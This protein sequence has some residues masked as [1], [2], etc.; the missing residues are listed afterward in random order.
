[1]E[2]NARAAADGLGEGLVHLVTKAKKTFVGYEPP[3]RKRGASGR[4]PKK[5]DRVDVGKNARRLPCHEVTALVGGRETRL[6]A[7]T[8]DLVWGRGVWAPVRVVV[9]LGLGTHKPQILVTTDLTLSAREVIEC[10][11]LRWNIECSFRDMKVELLGLA[12]RFWSR[13]VPRLDRFA[14][15]G[16][17]DRLESVTDPADRAAILAAAEAIERYVACSCVA[18][19]LLQVLTQSERE[20][21]P[22]ARAVFRR[23][24]RLAAVSVVSLREYLRDRVSGAIGGMHGSEMMRF[25][26]D[27]QVGPEGYAPRP[28]QVAPAGGR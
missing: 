1:M 17:P 21:G 10:Y 15:R 5:G 28:S 2:E 9:V 7:S 8:L 22:V 18:L 3:V 26:R 27:H 20:D 13:S 12:F 16:T 23:T 25:I 14:K 11:S 6:L 4:P 19:G 24:F